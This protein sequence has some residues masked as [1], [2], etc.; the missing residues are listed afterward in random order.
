VND[1]HLTIYHDENKL[2]FDK[3]IKTCRFDSTQIDH[4]LSHQRITA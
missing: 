1:F 4:M 3:M 2:P